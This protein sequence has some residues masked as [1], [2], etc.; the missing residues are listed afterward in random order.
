MEMTRQ[1]DSRMSELRERNER[2]YT[3]F[4]FE[5]PDA[6]MIPEEVK[7]R[8]L[9]E[10]MV[11][12][13]IRIT[14]KGKDDIQNVSK[15]FQDGWQFVDPKDVP[16]MAHSSIVKDE[17]RYSGT[18]CRGD[19]ALAKMPKARADARQ[20]FYENRSREMMDA[21]NAQLQKHNDSR[22]PVSNNS[23]SSVVTGRLPKFDK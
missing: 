19:L 8:F 16:E 1:E 14:V 10:G 21:V 22:A 12:R 9:A 13:W 11:L 15:R 23:K 17:G 2:E 7:D 3:D 6:L 4:A 5:E 20:A 18:V